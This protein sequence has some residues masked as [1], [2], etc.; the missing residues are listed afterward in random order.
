M[1][2]TSSSN[3]TKVQKYK[4]QTKFVP[5]KYN[6]NLNTNIKTTNVCRKCLEIVEWK[7]QYGKYKV[8]S[9]PG[10]CN[11]CKNRNILISYHEWCLKCAEGKCAKCF[12][13]LQGDN[14]VEEEL[15]EEERKI[16]FTGFSERQK[17]SIQRKLDAGDMEGVD[18]ILAQKKADFDPFGSESESDEES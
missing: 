2:T 15:V 5:N 13:V 17:R 16:D 6:P 10:K 9:Q 11:Q 14:M 18:R 7:K 8:R 1:P 12:V 4:N 3:Q